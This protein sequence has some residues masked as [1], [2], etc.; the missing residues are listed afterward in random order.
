MY[1]YMI[2]LLLIVITMIYLQC[3]IYNGLAKSCITTGI[4]Y[5]QTSPD[6]IH[7]YYI[8]ITYIYMYYIWYIYHTDI[9]YIYHTYY[10][11]L[12]NI[13]VSYIIYHQTYIIYIT[14]IL[15]YDISVVWIGQPSFL[16]SRE[17]HLADPDSCNLGALEPRKTHR[18][19][20]I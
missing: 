17:V 10:M 2:L 3:I 14:T 16:I 18:K 6:W 19:L 15:I 20:A 7:K 5:H 8:Y 11:D 1:I 13:M 4:I 9:W 12:S